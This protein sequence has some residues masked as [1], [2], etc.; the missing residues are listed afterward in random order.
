M[1]DLGALSRPGETE[2]PNRLKGSGP[3]QPLQSAFREHSSGLVAV[4]VVA[5]KPWEVGKVGDEV[6][7]VDRDEGPRHGERA[8]APLLVHRLEALKES[9]DQGVRETGEE[10]KTEHNRLGDQHDPRTHPDR[11]NLFDRD[12]RLLQL[13]GSVDVGI[14][15]SLASALGFLVQDNGRAALRHEKVDCLRATVE[16][17]LDPEVPAPVE[18]SFD[19]TSNDTSDGCTDAG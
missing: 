5:P 4:V 9:E 17:Q 19:R 10:R 12:A 2:Q 1:V 7:Q 6:G 18:E 3:Q 8:K 14:F 16:D 11:P 13:V 15:T